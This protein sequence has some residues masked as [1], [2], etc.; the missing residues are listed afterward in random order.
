[1]PEMTIVKDIATR[2]R[3]PFERRFQWIRGRKKSSFPPLFRASEEGAIACNGPFRRF[4]EDSSIRHSLE[5]LEPVCW[6]RWWM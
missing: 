2:F 3:F 6:S 5:F 4:L 1:M